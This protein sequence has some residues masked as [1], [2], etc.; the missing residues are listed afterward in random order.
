MLL[1]STSKH[2]HLT[3]TILCSPVPRPQLQ[4]LVPRLQAQRPEPTSPP[5]L[6]EPLCN[7]CQKPRPSAAG[8][9]TPYAAEAPT[10]YSPCSSVTNQL[11]PTFQQE[12]CP[13]ARKTGYWPEKCRLPLSQPTVP[14]VPQLSLASPE[15]DS[16]PSFRHP[17]YLC[18]LLLINSLHSKMLCVWKFFSHLCLDGLTKV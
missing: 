15:A 8:F 10:Q 6:T 1:T 13:E 14:S 16:L 18:F 17:H 9:L 3:Q 7:C 12:F 4:G 2:L 11:I 5:K